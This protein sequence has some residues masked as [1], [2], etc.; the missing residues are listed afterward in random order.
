MIEIQGFTRKQRL[1]ADIIW[2]LDTQDQVQNFIRSLP[3]KDREQAEVITEMII[4]AFIDQCD[5]VDPEVSRA[6]DQF[7]LTK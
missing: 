1:L 6:I 5:T 2:A 4:L 7:R 3:P